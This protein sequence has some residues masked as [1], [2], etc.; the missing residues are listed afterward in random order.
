MNLSLAKWSTGIQGSYSYSYKELTTVIV[1][2]KNALLHICAVLFLWYFNVYFQ[3]WTSNLSLS[4]GK[5]SSALN[6]NREFMVSAGTAVT[7]AALV[8]GLLEC[9]VQYPILSMLCI[10]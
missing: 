7:G 3:R 6:L 2:V 10:K 5:S 9:L 8:V 1:I 4:N